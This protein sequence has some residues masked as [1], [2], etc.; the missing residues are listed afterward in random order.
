VVCTAS[1]HNRTQVESPAVDEFMDRKSQRL[2]DASNRNDVVFDA[3]GGDA[4]RQ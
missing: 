4:Q 1:A 3:V 2:G